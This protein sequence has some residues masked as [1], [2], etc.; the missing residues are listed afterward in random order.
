MVLMNHICKTSRFS[1]I[2]A[3]LSVF[4][5][6][7]GGGGT[8][9]LYIRGRTSDILRSKKFFRRIFD[10]FESRENNVL[11]PDEKVIREDNFQ[12]FWRHL[13]PFSEEFMAF[14]DIFGS[15]CRN[16]TTLLG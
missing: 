15:S 4:S 3:T 10:T 12:K 7:P 13:V 9:E 5:H 2:N 6:L 1:V 11:R 14:S 8:R 16:V